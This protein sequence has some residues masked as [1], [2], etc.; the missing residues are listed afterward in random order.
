VASGKGG[1]GKSTVS[2]NLAIALAADGSAVGLL[3]ADMYGPDIPLMFGLTRHQEAR[4]VTVWNNPAVPSAKRV[5]VERHGVKLMSVQFLVGERQALAWDSG[6]VGLLLHQF[7]ERVEWGNLDFLIVDLPPGTADTQQFVSAV[8]LAGVVVVVTPQ[9]VAHLDAKK[10]LTMFEQAAVPVFGAVENMAWTQCPECGHRHG[11]FPPVAEGRSIWSL[12]VRRLTELPFSPDVGEIGTP[13][14]IR[15][16]RS[17]PAL[18][19]FDLAA[20]IRT[21]CAN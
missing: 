2:A 9:D 7:F 14:V 13:I 4:T 1:V 20:A 5:P 16:P 21:L 3:D 10:L 8:G 17:E 15:A 12:G 11:L 18:A 19:F 6:L